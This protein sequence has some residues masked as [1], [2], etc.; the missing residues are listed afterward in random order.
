MS[1]QWLECIVCHSRFDVGPMFEGCPICRAAKRVAGLEVRY[2]Y[3]SLRFQAVDDAPGIWKWGALM[4]AIHPRNRVS[5]GEGNTPLLL[6]ENWPGAAAFYVKNE[7][8]NPTWS[9][10]DRANSVSVS[11]AKE[12]GFPNIVAVSTGNHGNAAAAYAAAAGKRCLVFCHPNA[13]VAQLALMAHYGATVVRG[14]DQAA[15]VR[16]LVRGGD[17]FP[18]VVLC[19]R[20]GH[21]NPFGVEG[22]KTI[23]FELFEQLGRAPDRLFIPVGSGDGLYG[24]WKGFME[25]HRLGCITKMPRLFACQAAGANPYVRALRA[26]AHRLTALD[27][28]RTIALS[29]EE[30]IGGQQSLD[31]IYDSAGDALQATE[32]EILEMTRLLAHR[33]LA[34]E[35]ASATAVACARQVA[36]NAAVGEIWVGIGTGSI[37]KWPE[38]FTTDFMQPAEYPPTFDSVDDLL[39]L[40]VGGANHK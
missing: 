18:A 1:E 10:K 30:K 39:S 5:L 38:V 35:P 24:I 31:A 36:D 23:A 28:A 7:T 8:S 12:F 3:E 25:L 16:T 33:G 15:M 20:E 6:L 17:W 34:L 21:G 2:D 40:V 14:G 32:E 22:F 26:H 37:V 4:P 11:M 29:I 19:P 27:S 9:Y 13:P